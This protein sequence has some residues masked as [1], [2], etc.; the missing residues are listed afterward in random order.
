MRLS[1]FKSKPRHLARKFQVLRLVHHESMLEPG[2]A[3]GRGQVAH[4]HSQRTLGTP[5]GQDVV[6]RGAVESAVGVK[7]CSEVG[8]LLG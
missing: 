4:C 7:L 6:E 5:K 8:V 1:M 2:G 3:P